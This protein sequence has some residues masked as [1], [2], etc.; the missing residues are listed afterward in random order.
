MILE[1]PGRRNEKRLAPKPYDPGWVGALPFEEVFDYSYDGVMRSFDDSQARLGLGRI[2]VL[3]IH[4]IGRATHGARHDHHWAAL[5]TGG[6]FRA[7]DALRRAGLIRAIGVGAN[8][9]EV[10]HDALEEFDLDCCLVAGR[11][12]L[13]D[14]AAAQS[15]LPL[16]EKR[17]V[18]VFIGGP[19][20]SGILAAPAGVPKKFNY[21]DADEATIRRYEAIAAICARHGV[22]VPAAALQFP[23]AHPAVATVL[24]GCRTAE[25][26]RQAASWIRAPIPSGLW[27]DFKAKDLLNAAATVQC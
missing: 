7:L 19:F 24:V 5:T 20:N 26:M 18:A 23:L 15:L 27:A 6:G 8:E 14:Q 12:T 16:C 9:T 11:Y 21:R 3:Q 4:D 22:P 25:E 17:G 2:D 13:L 10:I 1:R